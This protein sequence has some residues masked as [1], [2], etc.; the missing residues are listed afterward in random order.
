VTGRTPRGERH[1]PASFACR[2]GLGLRSLRG[3]FERRLDDP[4][5]SLINKMLRD[6][7]QRNAPQG[8]KRRCLGG[9]SRHMRRPERASLRFL[10]AN[11]GS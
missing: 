8:G 3:F 4:A 2:L 6:L 11:D 9:L 1:T 10:L 5:M 7:D